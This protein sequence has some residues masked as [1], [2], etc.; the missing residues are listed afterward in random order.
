MTL[1]RLYEMFHEK[2]PITCITAHDALSS[3]LAD[4]AGSDIILVGDS[5][6]MVAMGLESTSKIELDEMIYHTK[7]V[8][9][10]AQSAFI[11]ADLP[12][13]S[14][15]SSTTQACESAIKMIKRG[16]AE[17]VKF[18][19]GREL[20]PIVRHLSSF[21]IC[22]MPHIGL[23]PQRQVSTGGFKVQG[24]TAGSALRIYEDALILQEAGASMLLLEGVPDRIAAYISSKLRIP[25]IGI[26]AGPHTS[27][28]VLVQIDMLGGFDAFTP[29]FLKRYSNY[30]QENTRAI[31]QYC[32]EVKQREFPERKHSYVIKDEE[33]EDFVKL[34]RD[35]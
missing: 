3:R 8:T 18:E 5:L 11:V 34:A 14:Y 23:T 15:E 17:A 13:G 28:Q 16:G 19:G 30:L 33:F 29:K 20:E 24:R 35:L 10:G 22:T 4:L 21:G 7:A 9:R 2:V 1:P 26:G 32:D 25:T 31:K 6:A 12:F 27:G